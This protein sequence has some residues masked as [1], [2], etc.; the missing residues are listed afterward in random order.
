MK[1][2]FIFSTLILATAISTNSYA[3]RTDNQQA[4]V[5]GTTFA[6]LT[7]AGT[8]AAGPVGFIL[9]ALGGAFLADQS[10]QANNAELALHQASQEHEQLRQ[11]LDEKTG[12]VEQMEEL[13]A[14]RMTFQ[15]LFA[16]GTDTLNDVDMQ[17][18]K[19][20]ADHLKANPK[21]V[22][23]LDGHADPRGT[24]EYNNVLS[25]ERAKAVKQALEDLGIPAE[26]ISHQG[27]GNRFSNAIKGDE[28]AYQQ[29]R[30]VDITIDRQAPAYSGI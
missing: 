28:D 2:P 27:H 13:A 11:A 30:R 18:I 3:A 21:L 8:V 17:R 10:R 15:V 7:I 19:I 26:R 20:L 1:T 23:S 22:V 4:A 25:Q 9:G 5:E 24:D 12:E 14:E 16:S 29:E 6:G